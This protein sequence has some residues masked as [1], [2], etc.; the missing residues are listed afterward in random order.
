MQINALKRN[1]LLDSNSDNTTLPWIYIHDL[2]I[3]FVENKAQESPFK[4]RRYLVDKEGK[5]VPFE[6]LKKPS[7]LC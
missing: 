2:F 3:D 1:G 4:K 6:L 5:D 7:G